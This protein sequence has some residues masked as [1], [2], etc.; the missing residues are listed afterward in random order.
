[1]VIF[2]DRSMFSPI[3]QKIWRELVIDM[4]EHRSIRK[5]RKTRK[6]FIFVSLNPVTYFPKTSVS[7]TVSTKTTNLILVI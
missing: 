6:I 4:A 2:Q 7:L 5:M 1:M 3:K